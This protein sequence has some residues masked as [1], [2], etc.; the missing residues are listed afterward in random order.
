MRFASCFFNR[1]I[2]EWV[3]LDFMKWRQQTERRM[4]AGGSPS[5][6]LRVFA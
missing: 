6:K 3:Q 4:T 5:W 1:E 2:E